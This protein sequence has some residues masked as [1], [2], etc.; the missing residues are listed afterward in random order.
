MSTAQGLPYQ[1]GDVVEAEI[2]PSYYRAVRVTAVWSN[3]KHGKPGWE[4]ELIASTNP[5]DAPGEHVWGYDSAVL[6]AHYPDGGWVG[7]DPGPLE[8]PMRCYRTHSG[9]KTCLE[10]KGH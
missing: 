4:G 10:K 8:P 5:Y 9:Q 6:R 7:K 3:V 1:A 2:M